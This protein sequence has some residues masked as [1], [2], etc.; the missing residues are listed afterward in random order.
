MTF[1]PETGQLSARRK[2]KLGAITLSS[3]PQPV[4]AGVDA[5]HALM[6]AVRRNGLSILPWDKPS[7]SRR[8]RL[9]W[10]HARSGAPWPD[11]GDE[12]LIAT[13]ETWLE[14]FLA[15]KTNLRT[16]PLT[17]ALILLVGHGAQH[18]LDRLAPSHFTAPTGS[19][20]ALSYP[21]DGAAPELAIRVQELFG[22]SAHPTVMDGA[23]PLVIELLS[24]A[25]RPI[26]RTTD[27]PAFWVGS[28]RDVRADMRGRYP[29]HPWPENPQS[30]APTRRAKP[31]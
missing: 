24:P 20:V 22:L 15:G 30:A 1:Q 25:H 16:V 18:E 29:K 2:R 3:A 5:T 23:V 26:Q 19:R 31:R 8:D 6:D 27:L 14:P 9:A 4:E 17:N 28:W 12:A 21:P 11:V 13:L 10:L 7:K